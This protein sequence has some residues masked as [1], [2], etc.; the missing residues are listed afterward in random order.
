MPLANATMVLGSMVNRPQRGLIVGTAGHIDHGKTS[1]IRALTGIDTDRLAEEKRRGISIDLGFAHLNLPNGATISFIDV[2]GHERFIKNML[3]GASGIQAVL[4]IVAAD[5]S[6][7]P[8][9]REHFDICR[10]LGLRHG[11]V[12]LTKCDVASPEQIR[13]A[14]SDVEVLCKDSFLSNAPIVPVSA[15]KGTGLD[16]V[17]T[18]LEELSLANERIKSDGIARLPIDRSFSMKGFGTVV[19]GT[20]A[21]GQL[22]ASDT[23]F[24]HP[25]AKTLRI[26]GLQVHG[27]T[28]DQVDAG[29]RTAVNLA[30]IE[31]TAINRG[32][33][34]TTSNLVEPSRELAI[35]VDWLP[36]HQAAHGREQLLLH[37]GAAEIVAEM[38][39]LDPA[40]SLAWLWLATPV[41]AFPG[42]RFILRRPSPATTVAG[43]TIIEAFPRLRLKRSK[44]IE[45]L[46]FLRDATLR[47][48]VQMLVEES[49][50]G[51]L[52]NALV[53]L[54]GSTL[55]DLT[56]AVQSN[57]EV[58]LHTAS[59]RVVSRRWVRDRQA[60]VIGWLSKFHAQNPSRNGAPIAAVRLGLSVDLAAIIF[61][62]LQGIRISGDTVALIS[63]RAQFDERERAAL[64][65]IENSFR[66]GGFAPPA[67]SDVL[68][69]AA[70]DQPKARS[71]LDV[72]IKS[73]KLVRVSEELV[74][75]A[76][77]IAHIR[78]SLASHKGRRFSVPEFKEWTQISRKFAIPLLEYL[79]Q[80]RVT[81]R[82]GD[83][84]IVL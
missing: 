60:E 36:G 15:L 30:G 49:P 52:L 44:T 68:K 5:E 72:L 75:H 80:A 50:R 78:S 69:G 77:V 12:V 24:L 31:S 13:A 2:P 33:V 64:E 74:F 23:I 26:R 56:A 54:C 18:H 17:R 11:F 6:V 37:L 63:H 10:M 84:R 41:L 51:L 42:D 34:L 73:N 20:L 82:D 55:A 48:H 19:T 28:V 27:R 1:L 38:K 76:D 66:S 67:V 7:K 53:R 57:P 47:G 22:R 71:L 79:D 70:Q 29:E 59:Q 46:S 62:S 21:G 65:K 9:T 35:A 58:F 45:R 8:Q 83:N 3:A 32:D 25:G 16:T 14:R 4:L 39:T 40:A 43:G 61:E 81:K